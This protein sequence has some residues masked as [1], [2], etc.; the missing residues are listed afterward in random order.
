MICITKPRAQQ[1]VVRQAYW[2]TLIVPQKSIE[3]M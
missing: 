2:E 3:T 1:E